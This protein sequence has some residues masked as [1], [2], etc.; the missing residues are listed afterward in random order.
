MPSVHASNG[1]QSAARHAEVEPAPDGTLGA[2]RP[3]LRGTMVVHRCGPLAPAARA[4][5]ALVGV[6]AQDVPAA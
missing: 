2:T 4:F 6:D 1:G 3:A 5:L